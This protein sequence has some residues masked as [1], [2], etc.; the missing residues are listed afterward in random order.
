[1]SPSPRILIIGAGVGGLALAQGFRKHGIDFA[2]F[3]KDFELDSRLQGYRLKI[4][5]EFQARLRQLLTPEAWSAFDA[6]CAITHLGE[7]NLNATNGSIIASREE[8]LPEGASMPY[9]IDRGMM[10]QSMMKGIEDSVHFGKKFVKYELNDQGVCVLFE[11][12]SAEQ[13]TLLVG[14][15]GA[16]SPVRKQL[17]PE[18]KPVDT[19]TCCIYGKTYLKPGFLERFPA[20]YRRW[21][22]IIR[23][24]TPIIQS[25]VSGDNPL[26]LVSEKVAF[27]NRNENSDLPDDYI[28]WGL[29]FPE[30]RSGLKGQALDEALRSKALDMSLQ[31]TAEWD[32]ALRSLIE[33]QEPSL[34]MG[35]R[36]YSASPEIPAWSSS[37]NITVIGD[38]IHVMPPSGGVG[39]VATLHDASELLK[40]VC[41]DGVTQASISKFEETIRR[42]AKVCITRSFVAGKRMLNM[43]AHEDCSQVHW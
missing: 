5:G 32:P 34:T 22:T 2:V 35:M 41:G 14:A 25:I 29:M 33:L 6:T 15:D 23:D 39:A 4:F 43:P 10:R 38:A 27:A 12:G 11:D 7:T 9:T 20:R 21:M 8:R 13:G 37:P 19:K 3:E 31:L 28:H 26:T 1:M 17:L 24:E 42:F 16:R 40:T 36:M 30:N 18:L